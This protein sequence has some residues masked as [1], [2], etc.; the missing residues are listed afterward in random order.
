MESFTEFMYAFDYCYAENRA[1]TVR[2]NG[3]VWV[4][5]P[6]GHG[7]KADRE[8]W[9]GEIGMRIDGDGTRCDASN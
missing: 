7:E 4:L 8:E 6:D 1:V 5:F 3:E 9:S 2:I